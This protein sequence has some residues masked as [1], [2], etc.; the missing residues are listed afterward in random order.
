MRYEG[1]SETEERPDPVFS[2]T[3]VSRRL[4]LRGPGEKIFFLYISCSSPVKFHTSTYSK[5]R[6]KHDVN[7]IFLGLCP[8]I[9]LFALV[10][11]GRANARC[12]WILFIPIFILYIYSV[13]F[14]ASDRPTS[15][16]MLIMSFMLL[17]PTASDYILLRP[18]Q[19]ELRKIGQKKSTS[20]MTFT[21]RLAWALSLLATPRGIGWAHEPTAHLPPRPTASRGKFIASQLLWIIFYTILLDIA[22]T[23]GLQN[24][25]YWTEG[26]SF[27]A[28]GWWWQMTAC[29][30]IVTLYC[31][32][33]GM[34]A[35]LS[36][37]SVA[38]GLHEPRD[39][40]HL[41]GP[42]R[43]AYTVRK[44]WGYVLTPFRFSR[45]THR[46]E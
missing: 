5:M 16:Y 46:A 18:H 3:M 30:H 43:D 27:T 12:N 22:L 37:I 29:V 1:A 38:T 21:E 2:K 35:I 23:H 4:D 28:F 10:D 33:S 15:D 19:R 9:L 45:D 20:E 24:P 17:I 11:G 13:F 31:S 8:L 26:P 14:C 44:C 6:G 34:Y 39:W 40:P 41:F 36:I 32:M 7:P 25:C 42:L